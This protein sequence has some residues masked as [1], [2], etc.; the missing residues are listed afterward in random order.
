MKCSIDVSLV[1]YFAKDVFHLEATHGNQ[2]TY[3]HFLFCLFV[4]GS[5]VFVSRAT[6]TYQKVILRFPPLA[7]QL[8]TYLDNTFHL[9][10]LVFAAMG[11]K[12]ANG[13][14]YQRVL[15]EISEKILLAGRTLLFVKY[16]QK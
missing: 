8:A 3:K 13:I 10:M 12:G 9:I 16:F 4:L 7:F 15:P 6:T 5:Y 14:S 1:D 2:N 11:K